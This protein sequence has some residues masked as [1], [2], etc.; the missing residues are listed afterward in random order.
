MRK[1]TG[2]NSANWLRTYCSFVLIFSMVFTDAFLLLE[3]GLFNAAKVGA[4][5]G[6]FSVFRQAAGGEVVAGTGFDV[7]WDTTL[8]ESTN[9][10]LNVNDADIAL[11]DGG[12]YL[13]LY[14]TYTE[15]GSTGGTNRRSISSYLTLDG[16]PIEAG[17]A[18][19]Y[20]RDTENNLSAYNSGAAIIDATTN[21]NLRVE[22]ER[23]DANPSAGTAIRA[24]SNGVS[25]LKLDD[26]L[27]YLRIHKASNSSDISANSSFTDVTWDT[28]DEVDTGSFAFT[29]TAADVTLKGGSEQLFLVTANVKLN[30][31][32]GSGPR[33]NYELRLTLDGTEVV[34]TRSSSYLRF[35]NGTTNGTLQYVGIVKKSS[36][37]DQTF[38]VE[39]R[40]AGQAAGATNIVGGETALTMVALPTG[41]EVISLTSSSDQALTTSQS[42]MTWNSQLRTASSYF[43]HSTSTNNDNIEIASDGNYLF[44]STAYTSRSAGTGRDVPKLDWRIDGSVQNYGGHGSY[45]RG[46]EGS[47]D[48]YTSGSSGGALFPNLTAGQ[49][50]ELIQSD[51]TTGTPVSNFIADRIALQAVE[52]STLIG[53]ATTD[54][55]V[56]GDQVLTTTIPAD[57]L[58]LGEQFAIIE[59][60]GGRNITNII[61]TENGTIDAENNLENV[62]LYYDLDTT[63]PYNCASESYGGSEAQFGAT[64]TFSGADGTITFTSSESISQTQAFCG[65]I[66]ADVLATAQ[67]GETINVEIGNPSSDVVVTAG[68]TVNPAGSVGNSLTTIVDAAITQTGYHWRNDDGS[69]VGATSATGGTENTP[70]LS[71]STSTPQRLRIGLAAL[72]SESESNNYRLEYSE[73]VTTCSLATGWTEVGT[74]GSD[75]NMFDSSFLTEASNTTNISVASGGV[76]DGADL[77]LSPNGG[78]RDTSAQTGSI[79]LDSDVFPNLAEFKN[80]SVTNGITTTINLDNTY[81]DPIVVA[82]VRYP[83][84]STQRTVRISNKTTSA[85]DVLVDNFDGSLS[86][87]TSTVDYLVI[88]AGEWTIDDGGTGTK[89]FASTTST[90]VSAG[91]ALP[92]N[93]GGAAVTYPSTFT[94][95]TVLASVVTTNDSDW[96][97]ATVYDG[98][99]VDNPPTSSGLTA[100]LNDNWDAD[101]HTAAEDIDFIV[102]EE[103]N[104]TNNSINFDFITSGSA[105]VSNTPITINY[106]SA[107]STTPSVIIVQA[108]TQ[109]GA[110]GGFAQVDTDTAPTASA[111]TLSTDEDGL[112]ADRGHA[113]EE[114][115]VISF[116][117][118]GNFIETTSL[119]Q[120]VELEYSIQATNNATE[121]VGYCFRVTDAGTPLKNYSEYPEATLSSDVSVGAS[122]T[123]I[124]TVNS[125]SVDNY[126]GG[127]FSITDNSGSRDITEIT[128]TE[129][130]TV[131]ATNLTSVKLFYELD[132]SAPYNCVSESYSGTESQYGSTASSF[133]GADGTATFN[134]SVAITDTSALCVYTVYSV[135]KSV[136]DGQTIDLSINNPSLDVVASTGSIGPGSTIEIDG[137]TSIAAPSLT[138]ANYH[139]RNDNGNEA[140]ASSATNGIENTQVNGV[141]QKSTQRLRVAISND[142]S[143]T[144]TDTRLRLEYGT[145]ITTCENVGSWQRV[146][147][148]VAF[149]MASTSQLINGNDTI[150][151]SPSLGGVSNPNTTFLS[152]NGAQLENSD[153]LAS[154]TI[155]NS[156]YIE[157]EYALRLTEASAFSGTYCFR[158]TDDGIPI[159]TY[160]NYP[161]LSVQDRQD[162]YIQ[163][164][165][166]TVSGSGV[167]LVAG[168]DYDAPSTNSASFVRIT[169][170]SMTG[171]GSITLGQ[172]RDPNEVFA[173]IENGENLTTSFSI[174]RPPGATDNTRVSW[175]I[176]EY[177]GISGADNEIIVR[178][179][180][181]VTYGTSALFA[182]GTAATGIVDDSAVVVFITGQYN[183]ATNVNNYNTGLSIS[184]WDSASDRPVFERGDADG[185]AA[186]VSYAVVEFTGAN[187]RIQRTE[188]TFTAAGVAET[189]LITAVNS[190]QRTFLHAQKLS[191][192]ELFNLDESGHEVWLSSIGAVSFELE[193]GST[194]PGQQRSVAWV[195][196]NTQL[197][198]GSLGV[199]RTNGLIASTSTQ[200]TAY[201]YNIGST[202]EPAN[203]SIW[204]TTRSSGAGSAHPRAQ[205]GARILN[206]T[207]FELWKS[208]EGQ[209]QNFRVEV[210]DWPVAETSIRQTHYRFYVDND[211]LTPTDPWPVGI[212]S[213]LG[214]NTPI[215]DIDEPLGIGERVRIRTSLFINNASLVAES[216]NFKLQYARRDTT[217]SAI[218]VWSDVGTTGSGEVWRGYNGT[219]VDGTEVDDG[220][221]LISVS[222]IAGTYEENSPSAINPNLVD[223]G[224]YVEYDWLVENN[225]AIQKSSYCFRMVESDGSLLDG[226]D[227]YPTVRTSGYTPII[228]NWRWYDDETSLTPTS[229]L[230]GENVSP[231]SVQN[232]NL[233][234]LRVSVTEIEGAPGDNIKFNLEYS[235]YPDFRDGTLLTSTT[236]CSGN[237]L[238]CY[239]DGNGNDNDT[240]DTTVLSGVDSCSA[241]VGTGCGTVNEAAGLS[242]TYDQPA[243]S[244]SEHEFTLRHDGARVDAVYYFRLVDAT[245]GVELV[246][247]SSFPSLTTAGAVFTFVVSGIDANVATEGIITNATTTAESIS[248]GSLPIDAEIEIAQRLTVFTNG[249]EGYRI[250]MEFDQELINSYGTPI[251][252]V[253]STNALPNTW[254]TACTGTNPGCFGYHSGDNSLYNGSDRFAAD[255]TYAGIE[256]GPV[257]IMAS[258]IPVTFDVSDIVYKTQVG[259]LQ[260]AGDYTTTVTYI[261]V[262]VF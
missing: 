104:G 39:V 45:N 55:T 94:N 179:A 42:V 4:V 16:T 139:W 68:G 177:I 160:S 11:T 69:E 38:N 259:F 260:P 228:N 95:P 204:A 112:G 151:I 255:D 78:V 166:Q 221:L 67:N 208:D 200:P 83:R 33:Q 25:V 224:E 143:I 8:S 60:Q 26:D 29:P 210:V 41:A 167:T 44:L 144:A 76:T 183:S 175:E 156:E 164:G 242:S 238:W 24:N 138:Q 202:V 134:Q 131:D 64:S 159:S 215:T 219:P 81:T 133:S 198:D 152:P 195:I 217:C 236:T 110:D 101:G 254:A 194:N 155:S 84:T 178:D 34:G 212:V 172:T 1:V 213:D 17:W 248:F 211:S 21:Q 65:Y 31:T 223:I 47:E 184:H 54:V 244:T 163:R 9:I 262:P 14:N 127:V 22:L 185:E 100:F 48:A 136:T 20:I 2:K 107:F 231:S 193:S 85:F 80:V 148:S 122:G 256:S 180:G 132:T 28:T 253:S 129:S 250:F 197:G 99:N 203:A 53:E 58:Y 18:T 188:H 240:I 73:K 72:G 3:H 61:F 5:A 216:V 192:D 171:A 106:S 117:S 230:A 63:L 186:R 121:G 35:D 182:T 30:V 162:F 124:A 27:D 237:S 145:K 109:L 86:A 154:T 261:A 114:V 207:Q 13:V 119:S 82:S 59:N 105:N 49:V 40:N 23:D 52:I 70:G 97:F 12:K 149:E 245:N 88:E 118:N 46:D 140:T 87:G 98:T 150:D 77:F 170:T 206:S 257:E 235:E 241:G 249:T 181:E 168:V 161:E 120:F 165:T 247:S 225:A 89:V 196:E 229:P 91:R 201:V 232:G 51:E 220:N 137:T 142:G 222:D 153:Q 74:G 174:V 19:G 43:T 233:L 239:A 71:F 92:D 246:A 50:V 258:D 226:Y 191:G 125:D 15:E 157:L 243:L 146:V 218:S 57:D 7:K 103:S 251:A 173:Y 96:T 79:I 116:Q 205:L 128:L 176:V 252:S 75:W 111:V 90:S 141:F 190:L 199:Y 169:D 93:P 113:A 102:F 10:V 209:N 115:A 189:E 234:K 123:Q 214:E 36:A 32:D 66:L 130:G 56:S 135:N 126:S 147:G 158:V 227:T 187:W 62:R 108:L 6:D 37:G